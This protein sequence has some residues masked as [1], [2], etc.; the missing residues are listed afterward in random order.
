M[1]RDRKSEKHPNWLLIKHRDEFAQD[2]NGAV[3]LSEDRSIASGRSMA[4]IAAGRGR[5]PKPFMLAAND[6]VRPDAV[7]DSN[8]GLAADARRRVQP[9]SKSIKGALKSPRR[10]SAPMP[11]FNA[12]QLRQAVS[13]PP[14]GTGWLHEIKFHGYRI[15]LRI[16][17]GKVNLKTRKGLDWTAK[18][19]RRGRLAIRCS[20]RWRDRRAQ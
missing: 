10:R 17:D 16:H 8:K 20:Y 13:R 11:D 9:P 18:F 1:K 2:G 19:P 7:W 14:N 4:T 15:Q 6:G 5:S 12:P 3:I